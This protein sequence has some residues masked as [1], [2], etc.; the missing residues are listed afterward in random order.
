MELIN[1][2]IY[3]VTHSI[4][5]HI[6]NVTECVLSSSTNIDNTD[7]ISTVENISINYPNTDWTTSITIS[8]IISSC[9]MLLLAGN[10]AIKIYKFRQMSNN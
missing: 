6:Y 1:C 8:I 4:C 7:D 10:I 2:T 9:I 5:K 3:N